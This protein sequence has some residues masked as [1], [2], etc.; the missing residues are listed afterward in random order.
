MT[1]QTHPQIERGALRDLVPDARNANRGTVRGRGML[2]QSLREAGAGRSIV[3]DR[4]RRIIGGNKTTEVA[5]EIGLDEVIFVHTTG[6]QLV[7]VVRDDLDL[8]TD[9]A[10]RK[11]AIADNRVA[12]VSLE[13]DESV[14]ASLALEDDG[15]LAGLFTADE[16]EAIFTSLAA[17]AEEATRALVPWTAAESEAQ[18]RGAAGNAAAGSREEGDAAPPAPPPSGQGALFPLAIVLGVIDRR[19]W[20]ACKERL[21]IREDTGAFLALL[22]QFEAASAGGEP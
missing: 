22:D 21:G 5:A 15:A 9:P 14:L 1:D 19:R 8:E 20:L 3:V 11:L 7:A 2:E 4:H 17:E 12:E 18:A 6:R 13:W 16:V 10:A